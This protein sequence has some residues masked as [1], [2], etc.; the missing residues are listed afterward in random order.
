MRGGEPDDDVVERADGEG[1]AEEVWVVDVVD[2][3]ASPA[4]PV[5]ACGARLLMD[6][7]VDSVLRDGEVVG[8]DRLL[9]TSFG[10]LGLGPP[11]GR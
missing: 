2:V 4:E 3:V 1:F 7:A 9:G 5:A 10:G 6:G 8:Q 11:T